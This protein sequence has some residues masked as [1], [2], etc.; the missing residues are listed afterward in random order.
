MEWTDT[1][2][3]WFSCLFAANKQEQAE[4][5]RN[6]QFGKAFQTRRTAYV[7]LDNYFKQHGKLPSQN[8]F[9]QRYS[10][11]LTK[12]EDTLTEVS[13]HLWDV[14]CSAEISNALEELQRLALDKGVAEALPFFKER[15]SLL[16]STVSEY[17][18][19]QC[20][21]DDTSFQRYHQLVKDKHSGKHTQID[22]PWVTLNRTLKMLRAGDTVILSARL[23]VG[24]TWILVQWAHHLAMQ[25]KKVLFYSKEMPP[26][27]IK[28]RLDALRFGLSYP[29]LRRGSLSAAQLKLWHQAR[30]RSKKSDYSLIISGDETERGVGLEE[31]TDKIRKLSPDVVFIDGAYLLKKDG[32][33]AVDE[34]TRLTHLSQKCKAVAKALKVVLILSVQ[35][36]R[37]AEAKDGSTKG[38]ITTIFGADAWAQDADFV[39]QMEG[40]RGAPIRKINLTKGRESDLVQFPIHFKLSPPC[41]LEGVGSQPLRDEDEK[42]TDNKRKFTPL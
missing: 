4:L 32:G 16:Q 33:K 25:K 15:L 30:E 39:L 28:D 24:K 21:S 3:I 31:V 36:N 41:F 6:P 29:D 12:T 26:A 35:M 10:C 17:S 5:L 19:I 14:Y 37:T 9:E 20:D 7:W 38:G 8:F 42:P 34:V 11:S 40:R 23:S 27:T 13:K 1:E 18:D 2:G 22:T